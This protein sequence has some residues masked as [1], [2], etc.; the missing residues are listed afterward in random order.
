MKSNDSSHLM[1]CVILNAGD[2]G[3]RQVDSTT[4]SFCYWFTTRK[5]DA[6]IKWHTAG[7]LWMRSWPNLRSSLSN[8]IWVENVINVRQTDRVNIS[9]SPNGADPCARMCFSFVFLMRRISTRTHRRRHPTMRR[10]QAASSFSWILYITTRL[11]RQWLIKTIPW[12]WIWT[13]I[14]S[15]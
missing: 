9:L 1:M 12:W 6:N 5:R 10:Q 8:D 7:S 4:Y 13:L 2:F 14:R 15:C 3:T 11:T